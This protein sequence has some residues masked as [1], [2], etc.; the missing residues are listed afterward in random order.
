MRDPGSFRTPPQRTLSM[1]EGKG[2]AGWIVVA[3]AGLVIFGF[4]IVASHRAGLP[5]KADGTAA[6]LPGVA[7]GWRLLFHVER[8]SALVG[9]FGLVAVILWRAAHGELPLKVGQLEYAK[10][11]QAEQLR[12]GTTQAL[13][14]MRRLLHQERTAREALAERVEQL[15]SQR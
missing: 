5:T 14:A 3:V 9:A 12:S 2:S 4:A 11:E 7:L 6:G 13:R 8:A 15:E 1:T 10:K